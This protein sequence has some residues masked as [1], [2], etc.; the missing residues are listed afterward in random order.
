[1][2]KAQLFA[3]LIALNGQRLGVSDNDRLWLA[4]A[5]E[6]EGEPQELV[7]A[8]LVNRWV[9]LR[10]S[11]LEEYPTLASLV[12]A[13]AQAVNPRFQAGG[14]RYDATLLKLRAAGD[15]GAVL[16]MLATG[17]RRALAS[18]RNVFAPS[19]QAAVDHALLRGPGTLPAGTVHFAMTGVRPQGGAQVVT[20]PGGPRRN[21]FYSVPASGRALYRVAPPATTGGLAAAAGAVLALGI[22]K[23]G[24]N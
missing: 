1:M 9:W 21:V 5:V 19:T 6:H 24:R 18:S 8:C 17:E 22:F 7:A 11:G 23:A 2:A 16:R 13:Y 10:S 20:V 14:D 15:K 4:R 12:R 3:V